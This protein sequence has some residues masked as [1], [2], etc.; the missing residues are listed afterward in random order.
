MAQ[1]ELI[2]EL[3][4]SAEEMAE[5]GRLI[6]ALLRTQ[7]FW[8]STEELRHRYPCTFV[9]YLV[10]QGMYGYEGGDYWSAACEG[11][12][13]PNLPNYTLA[14]GRT[15]EAIVE[16]LGLGHEFGGH[17]YVG[18]I[19][20]HGGIPTGSLPD[21]FEH[22]LQPSVTKPDWA[23]LSTRELIEEWLTR[24]P[25]YFV[26]KPVL[27]FLEYGRGVAEDFVERCRQMAAET[28][29]TGEIPTAA[30]IGLPESVVACY[31][32]WI[33]VPERFAPTPRTGQRLRRPQLVLEPWG[34]G[35]QLLLPEQRLPA[36]ENQKGVWWEIQTDEEV[37]KLPVQIRPADHYLR[38]EPSDVPLQRPAREYVVRLFVSGKCLKEWPYDG[39]DGAH[40][41]LV[42][43]AE[44]GRLWPKRKHLPGR[45]L[46][47]LCAPDVE[48][49][50]EPAS[51]RIIREGLPQLPW[52]WHGWQGYMVDLTGV[53]A[54]LVHT[55][56]G[57]KR[58][59]V[60]QESRE[61]ELVGGMT[62]V[63]GRGLPAYTDVDLRDESA[64]LYVGEPPR[65]R[66]PWRQT[67]R[68]ARWRLELW[69]EGEAEPRRNVKKTLNDLADLLRWEVAQP[70][71]Q[72]QQEQVVELPLSHPTLLGPSPLGQYRL[73]LRGPLG[74]GA[75]FRFRIVP[76]LVLTGHEALYLPDAQQGSL[77][78]QLLIETDPE[79][80]LELLQHDPVLSVQEMAAD[81]HGRCYQVEV[82]PERTEV[83][84]HLVH[85]LAP[86]RTVTVPLR[87]P[88]HRLR[89][90]LILRP[91]QLAGRDWRS[92]AV[93][94]SLEELEQ[95]ES[96]YLLLEVPGA[97][98]N[99]SIQLRFL[100]ADGSLLQEMEAIRPLS[101]SRF[102][103]FDLRLIRDTVRQSRSPAVRAELVVEGLPDHEAVTLPVLTIRRGV[104]VEQVTVVPH[105][106][107]DQL[108]LELAWQPDI[109]LKGRYVRFWSQTRPWSEPVGFPVADDARSRHT[110]RV[111]ADALP[112][113]TSLVE[114]TVRDPWVPDQPERPLPTAL[115]VVSIILGDL[116]E[117]L[118]QVDEA[119][120]QASESF[121]HVCERL[122][123]WR[124]LGKP[125][126]LRD[127]LRWCYEHMEEAP[128]KQ[129]VALARELQDHPTAK[130]I[131]FKLFRPERVR[132][133]LD[134][135]REGKLG[136]AGLR[137]YLAQMPRLALLS[138]EACEAL[139]EV[140][141]Y[142]VRLAMAQRLI[143]EGR[144]SGM[145]AALDWMARGELAPADAEG[146]LDKDP[147]LLVQVLV[148]R[149]TPQQC[150]DLLDE[151]DHPMG[152]AAAR[153][154]ITEGYP[155]GVEAVLDWAE[156]RTLYHF[157]VVEL[158]ECNP[159]LAVQVLMDH[160]ITET[161]SHLWNALAERHPEVA[162]FIRVGY[163]IRCRAGWGRI[164]RIET[165]D[166]QE[167]Y[168][169]HRDELQQGYRLHVTLHP[170]EEAES[171]IIDTARREI[172]FE[173]ASRVYVCGKCEQWITRYSEL[174]VRK[175]ERA[176][177][178]GM[179]ARFRPL[180]S[181]RLRQRAEF[182]FSVRRP[183]DIWQ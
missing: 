95:S 69:N 145:E 21:F 107:G 133:M 60:V 138:P 27:R 118:Q 22:M 144:T 90:M 121:P 28:V 128:I 123:L 117:R 47:T 111:S 103:S 146:L 170:D 81:A 13:L 93:T 40:P 54:L 36:T 63:N 83:P 46:W 161:T 24:S 15:F 157:R 44:T 136:E 100:D 51:R 72:P 78:V 160:P 92:R 86:D 122:F 58:I 101:P 175:H 143:E 73:R 59:A 74:R 124:A 43:D 88:I 53:S 42:F 14:W 177:H 171:V 116:E 9:A 17:R 164:E 166:G 25:H 26:D 39:A 8:R 66:I 131:Q 115:S 45:L 169:V 155:S 82:P 33:E 176:A 31:Q 11:A 152:L 173:R 19:L 6:Q 56:H 156:Q 80:R 79:S 98:E 142:E 18:A 141:D 12:G 84:L 126:R 97:A 57:V 49:D 130:A 174:I 153:R 140:P 29:E 119:V 179:G 112:V 163:W 65:L 168:Y 64:P 67:Y 127:D 87:V 105:W 148:S 137:D 85:D 180:R 62:T 48:L 139:L 7:G 77:P 134:A 23:G 125:E 61:P 159:A 129:L 178:E 55:R 1:I 96:P 41:L 165:L 32:E 4:L 37:E 147:D 114:F 106:E 20:G 182:E 89:W 104:Y 149:L 10:F 3:D 35:V 109:P 16:E 183:P 75:E 99:T 110:F 132:Q 34:A 158:L 135:Y 150:E 71:D 76:K 154:L 108:R 70:G 50:A 5:L 120:A 181:A 91:A 38:I 2:G 52:A 68:L 167:T 102:R 162:P 172:A 151:L 30:E 113:G 94:V